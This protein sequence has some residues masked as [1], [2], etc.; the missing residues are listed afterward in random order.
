[1][2][3]FTP[4]SIRPLSRPEIR[5]KLHRREVH[6]VDHQSSNSRGQSRLHHSKDHLLQGSPAPSSIKNWSWAKN[7]W[8]Q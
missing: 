8:I 4:T 2:D 7:I 6:L 5:G 1:M 3:S